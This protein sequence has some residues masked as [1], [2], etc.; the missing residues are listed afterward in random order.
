MIQSLGVFFSYDKQNVID[1]TVLKT[2]SQLS[3]VVSRLIIVCNME[4]D[5]GEMSKLLQYTDEVV[6]RKNVGFDMGAYADVITKY[7]GEEQLCFFDEVV[8]CND[9][10]FGPFVPMAD[11]VDKMRRKQVDI[12]GLNIVNRGILTHIQSYFL[13]FGKRTIE[14]GDLYRYFQE[15]VNPL[16]DDIKQVYGTAEPYLWEYFREKGYGLGALIDTECFDIYKSSD[17]CLEKY[18][19][20]YLK[21]KCFDKQFANDDVLYNSMKMLKIKYG[22]EE[23]DILIHANRVYGYSN[24]VVGQN[25]KKRVPPIN[26]GAS[27]MT[28]EDLMN[29]CNKGRFYIYGAGMIARQLQYL[30]C[31]NM[32]NFQGFI[33][34]RKGNISSV[35]NKP[36]YGLE[37]IEKGSRIIIGVNIELQEEIYQMI[38][39]DMCSLVLWDIIKKGK[40]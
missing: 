39:H 25:A 6:I 20:P 11:I 31:R 38:K 17:Y 5:E 28:P 23:E 9:T 3:M 1:K 7:I 27:S 36:V 35:E 15:E 37:E 26:M 40:W 18:D 29:W 30:Y 13:L 2:I 10:F 33:V 22:L 21:K 34:S 24:G 32:Q 4:L 8:L 14:T 19:M 16:E 12:C